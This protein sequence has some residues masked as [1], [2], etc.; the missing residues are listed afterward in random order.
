MDKECLQQSNGY[1]CGIHVI[2]NAEKLAEYAINTGQIGP[3]DMMGKINH[4][5][6]RKEIMAI[7]QSLASSP[8]Y[9]N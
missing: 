1:D 3:C 4:T 7:I 8:E 9:V 5:M 6:K 2:C